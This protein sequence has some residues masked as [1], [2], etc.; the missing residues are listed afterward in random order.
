MM[1]NLP[2]DIQDGPRRVRAVSAA[3][4]GHAHEVS[5]LVH[6]CMIENAMLNGEVVRLDGALG[7][8]QRTATSYRRFSAPPSLGDAEGAIAEAAYAGIPREPRAIAVQRDQ[9]SASSTF[10]TRRR[11][12][13]WA[14]E[15]N[16]TCSA[17]IAASTSRARAT[18]RRWSRTSSAI[19]L[20]SA[21]APLARLTG[22]VLGEDL[23]HLV[24]PCADPRDR[25]PFRP[26]RRRHAERIRGGGGSPRGARTAPL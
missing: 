5:R 4:L 2:P 8:A 3:G 11:W 15:T 1:L 12:T 16:S 22:G 21:A 17:S 10:P 13:R 19:F 14:A 23:T 20:S 18:L 26:L 6:A 7:S 9:S 24:P 25:P